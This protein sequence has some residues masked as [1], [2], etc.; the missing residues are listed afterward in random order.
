MNGMG[1]SS[2]ARHNLF[3]HHIFRISFSDDDDDDDDDFLLR[4]KRLG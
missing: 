2:L 3:I 1:E 4:R